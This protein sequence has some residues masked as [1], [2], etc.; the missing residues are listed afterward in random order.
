MMEVAK[1]YA[2]Q[3]IVFHSTGD[4]FCGDENCRFFNAH[5]QEGM[6][7][8]INALLEVRDGSWQV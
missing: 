6:I 4:A 1:G 2:L 8:K 3:A 5:W 7:E